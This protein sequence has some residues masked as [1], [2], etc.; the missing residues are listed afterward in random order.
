ML[1]GAGGL[2]LFPGTPLLEE[3]ERG[4]FDPLDEREMLVELRAFGWAAR[5][6]SRQ[7]GT[8]RMPATGSVGAW[9]GN[10]AAV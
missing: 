8:M 5:S 4:E 9:Y 2:T 7:A 10:G 6:L 3:P 1:V